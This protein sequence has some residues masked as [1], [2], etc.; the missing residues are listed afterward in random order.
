MWMEHCNNGLNGF[1]AT[2]VEDVATA[3]HAI[4]KDNTLRLIGQKHQHLRLV[5]LT[6]AN[7]PYDVLASNSILP[8]PQG[9]FILHRH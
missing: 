4:Q 7:G 8:A 1:L 6:T 5:T 9:L 2:P 3:L